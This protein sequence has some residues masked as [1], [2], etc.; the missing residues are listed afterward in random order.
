MIIVIAS[1]ALMVLGLIIGITACVGFEKKDTYVLGV[2]ESGKYDCVVTG[3][4]IRNWEDL[5]LEPWKSYPA[6]RVPGK[7]KLKFETKDTRPSQQIRFNIGASLFW[8]FSAFS[9][10]F[11]LVCLNTQND[12][13]QE[14]KCVSLTADMEKLTNRENTLRLTLAG[15]M[16]FKVTDS[17]STYHVVVDRPIDNK[18]E[19]D[20]YN[21]DVIE[22]K[23]YIYMEKFKLDNPWTSWFVNPG[24]TRMEHY[25]PNATCYSDILG[26]SLKTF[27]LNAQ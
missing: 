3:R 27:E 5:G 6:I 1:L 24:F 13:A 16:G 10:L 17:Q 4:N 14:N 19:V 20:N 21:N 22:F 9:L 18:A 8:V 7:R 26:D 15:D 25:N 11:G 12:I 2:A 23:R